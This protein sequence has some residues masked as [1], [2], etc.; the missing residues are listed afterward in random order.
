MATRS[1]TQGK[2]PPEL[3]PA[4]VQAKS[5]FVRPCLSAPC[6]L[7]RRGPVDGCRR[8]RARAAPSACRRERREAGG[9]RASQSC[10]TNLS[11]GCEKKVV[12]HL[13][14]IKPI[15]F[16]KRSASAHQVRKPWFVPSPCC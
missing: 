14:R 9:N 10:L 13:T 3:S 5:P 2:P 7:P 4:C 11:T 1:P 6:C 16:Q 15:K 8:R 12:V